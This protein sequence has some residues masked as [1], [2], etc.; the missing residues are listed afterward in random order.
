[1]S[2]EERLLVWR[3]PDPDR[4]DTARVELGTDRLQAHGTSCAPD[5]V[6]SYVLRTGAE[7]VTQALDVH[8]AG[9]AGERR[10]QLR[11]DDGGA[12]SAVRSTGG[13]LAPLDLPDLTGALDCDLGLCPLTNTMPILRG[14]LLAGERALR[15]AWVDVPSLVVHLSEQTYGTRTPTT[16]GGAIVG[17]RTADFRADI[18]VDADGLV[19]TYPGIATRVE[20]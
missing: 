17:F 13:A 5:Y 16:G 6:L 18:E 4:I 3:G 2:H 20:P 9:Q 19:V 12:W 11:R 1:M 10:L 15:M 14:R 8:V 7:W